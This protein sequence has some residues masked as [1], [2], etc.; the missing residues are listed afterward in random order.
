[1]SLQPWEERPREEAHLFNPA[2][3][4]AVLHE[5][6]KEYQKSR[7]Q[8]VP[9]VL[10][11]CMLPIALHGKT[12]RALPGSTLTSL[13]SWRERNPEVLVGF[14]QRARS[15]RP[16]VQEALRF[17]VDRT[18]LAFASDGGVILGPKP[19]SVTKKFEHTLTDD[20]RECVAAARLLGRWLAKAG[21]ASTI[22]AAWGIKP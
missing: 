17:A 5:F 12:R 21:T 22:L 6:V 1:M 16:I 13:Y 19:L 15:L 9:Y 18:V 4:A 2:F 20:A 10:L 14:A 3:C 8:A 11:F 7:G